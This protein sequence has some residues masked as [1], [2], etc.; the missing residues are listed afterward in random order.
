VHTRNAIIIIIMSGPG[1]PRCDPREFD[2]VVIGSGPGGSACARALALRGKRVCLLERGGYIACTDVCGEYSGC[3]FLCRARALERTPSSIDTCFNRLLPGRGALT[4]HALGGAS[5]VNFSLWITPSKQDLDG[6]LPQA[7]VTDEIVNGFLKDVDDVITDQQF[8]LSKLHHKVLRELAPQKM[9]RERDDR[10]EDGTLHYTHDDVVTVGRHLRTDRGQRH[11]AWEALAEEH[12]LICTEQGFDVDCIEDRPGGWNVYSS[13]SIP[14]PERVSAPMVFVACSALET[15]KVLM[16]SFGADKLSPQLGKNLC[17]HDQSST[18]YPL[19]CCCGIND[20]PPSGMPKRSPVGFVYG[21]HRG[22][23]NGQVTHLPWTFSC[24]ARPYN[25]FDSLDAFL[26]TSCCC[27]PHWLPCG[28]CYADLRMEAFRITKPN[29]EVE[30]D[31][32]T[33]HAYVRMPT[34]SCEDERLASAH[35]T[36]LDRAVKRAIG[37]VRGVTLP[38]RSSWHYT[39]TANAIGQI[40]ASHSQGQTAGINKVVYRACDDY[41]HV[42]DKDGNPFLQQAN[43]HGGLYVADNSLARFPPMANGMSMAAFCGYAAA[44][45]ALER[46]EA[47]RSASATQPVLTL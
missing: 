28:L 47:I 30:Y 35:R 29:G 10:P 25:C 14:G 34:T 44:R 20:F 45:R 5:A 46:E 1:G 23:V 6:A 11:N 16:R 37:E 33:K 31:P 26:S 24:P 42:L 17:D 36:L 15:P 18:S 4:G 39:G 43:G 32:Q 27:S 8:D 9:Q 41:A 22:R 21:S 13:R 3:A 7:M 2:A 19:C 12:P 40:T 38:W